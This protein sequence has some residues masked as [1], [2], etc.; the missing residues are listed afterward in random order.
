MDSSMVEAA[1]HALSYQCINLVVRGN[2]AKLKSFS[3]LTIDPVEITVE[4]EKK[5]NSK[6]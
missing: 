4:I 3:S 1:R 6:W 2:K 5:K